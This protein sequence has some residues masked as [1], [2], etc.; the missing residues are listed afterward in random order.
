MSSN[1]KPKRTLLA[2]CALAERLNKPG[3]GL[4]QAMTPFLAEACHAFSGEL[5][6][7]GK[8]STAVA[9]KFGIRIPRLAAL[10]LAE[11]LEK[12]GLLTAISG[13]AMSRVYR[14]SVSYSHLSTI[15]G[16]TLDWSPSMK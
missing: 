3:A 9:Q 13:Q 7:A 5:F 2:Y 10:G 6:D 12:E 15:A 16:Q 8:F 11:H 14:Y 1:T 4:I